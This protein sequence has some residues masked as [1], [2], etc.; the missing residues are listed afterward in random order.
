MVKKLKEI[1]RWKYEMTQQEKDV[2]TFAPQINKNT[3]KILSQR[4]ENSEGMA[5]AK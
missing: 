2:L 5:K 3:S 1:E 4:L